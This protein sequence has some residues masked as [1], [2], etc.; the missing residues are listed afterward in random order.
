[1]AEHAYPGVYLKEIDAGVKPIEGVDTSTPVLVGVTQRGPKLATLISG[2][3]DFTTVFGDAF[4]EL[5]EKLRDRW[6]QEHDEGGQWWQF[7][8]SVKGFFGNGGKRALIKRVDCDNLD[9][10]A[11][12]HFV[13]AIQSLKLPI[14]EGLCLGKGSVCLAPGMWSTKVQTALISHCEACLGFAILDP[15]PGLDI[16]GVREFRSHRDSSFAALYYPWLDIGGI[17]VASS[18]HV[19]GI[20]AR[21][22]RGRGVHKAPANEEILGI[23]KLAREVSNADQAL[24][25]RDGINA[26]RSFPGH[27]NRVWGAHTLSAGPEFKYVNVRRLLIYLEHSI[28]KGTQWTVF[29]PNNERTWNNVRQV[30]SDFLMNMWRDGAL[31][32]ATPEHAFFVKCD[33]ST[34]TQND[35]DNG[36]LICLIG[37]AVMKPAEFVLFRIGQWTA[38]SNA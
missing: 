25:N 2:Y 38:E 30:I 27:G 16:F 4:A 8:H 7:A 35:L 18:G 10:L 3:D 5:P 20:Y 17:E 28:D 15:P 9:S 33:R 1:M 11:A 32:G 37:V 22:D 24:L 36:R 13:S 23:S 19:A 12:D 31:M 29:E 21:S 14:G 34:M 6:T 26:L